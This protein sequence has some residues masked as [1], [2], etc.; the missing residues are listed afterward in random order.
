MPPASQHTQLPSVLNQRDMS[1]YSVLA[2]KTVHSC[3]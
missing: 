2:K 3:Y 1:K